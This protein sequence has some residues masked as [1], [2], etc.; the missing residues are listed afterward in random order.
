MLRSTTSST[1][2]SRGSSDS[3]SFYTR[4]S[5]NSTGLST[6][7]RRAITDLRNLAAGEE[8]VASVFLTMPF[9]P[10]HSHINNILHITAMSEHDIILYKER[11]P[12]GSKVKSLVNATDGGIL[13]T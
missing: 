6:V 13:L 1:D 7:L 4:G 5:N 10:S 9:V 8:E 3:R 12:Q 2:D 11:K